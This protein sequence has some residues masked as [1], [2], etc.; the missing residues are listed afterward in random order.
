MFLGTAAGR[1]KDECK[2]HLHVVRNLLHCK[3]LKWEEIFSLEFL[4]TLK[5]FT[6]S[7]IDSSKCIEQTQLQ[8]KSSHFT[9]QKSGQ[10]ANSW[11]GLLENQSCI[12]KS[13]SHGH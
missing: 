11:G 5:V 10:I 4:L 9:N 2:A 7:S 3:K 6:T 12:G 8:I 1:Q 13:R